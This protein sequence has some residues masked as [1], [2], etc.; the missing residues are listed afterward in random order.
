MAWISP[1][2]D[3]RGAAHLVESVHLEIHILQESPVFHE[4][5][6]PLFAKKVL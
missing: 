1:G 5:V 2:V 6:K 4:L 3:H